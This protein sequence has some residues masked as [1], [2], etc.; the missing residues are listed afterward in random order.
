MFQDARTFGNSEID[1]AIRKMK[2]NSSLRRL[3]HRDGLD[4][5]W[6]GQQCDPRLSPNADM[7]PTREHLIRL[8]DGGGS[9]MKNLVLACRKCNN[10]RHALPKKH[11]TPRE[12]SSKAEREAWI[13]YKKQCM[14]G[15]GWPENIPKPPHRC[16]AN[17]S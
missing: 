17:E 11:R 1:C 4:C 8:A 7:F 6:C 12:S 5:H 15:K 13:R 14:I 3:I 10:G 2:P 16:N 9:S